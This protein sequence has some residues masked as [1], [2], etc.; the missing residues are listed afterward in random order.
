MRVVVL[1]CIGAGSRSH[2]IIGYHGSGCIWLDIFFLYFFISY[3][4]GII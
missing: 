2:Y 1:G 3:A 4:M